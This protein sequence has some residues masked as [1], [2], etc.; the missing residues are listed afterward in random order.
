MSPW[1]SKVM[2]KHVQ[3]QEDVDFIDV[4][5]SKHVVHSDVCGDPQ[6]DEEQTADDG[7]Q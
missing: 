4:S 5:S 7:E 1:I 3:H 6:L 2:V